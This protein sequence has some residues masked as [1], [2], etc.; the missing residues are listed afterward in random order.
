MDGPLKLLIVESV[1]LDFHRIDR[2]MRQAA[3]PWRRYRAASGDDLEALV[4]DD[5]WAV[6][7]VSSLG[8]G[9]L[10]WRACMARI[11]R[12]H[13]DLPV[14]LVSGRVGAEEAVAA[15]K[16]GA[17]DFVLRDRLGDLGPAIERAVGAATDVQAARLAAAALH[18]SDT[19]L[20]LALIASRMGV[21]EWDIAGDT[22]TV[23]LECKEIMALG[24]GDEPV[25][26]YMLQNLHPDDQEVVRAAKEQ[27][28]A[29]GGAHEIEYRIVCPGS[30]VKWI[31]DHS[32]VILDDDGKP[33]RMLGTIDDVTG[34]KRVEEALR[35]SEM[36]LQEAQRI[37]RMGSFDYDIGNDRWVASAALREILGTEADDDGAAGWGRLIHPAHRERMLAALRETIASGRRFDEEYMIVRP[38]DGAVRWLHGVGE[39]RADAAGAARHIVGMN[40]DITEVRIARERIAGESQKNELLLRMASDGI[41][42]LDADGFVLEASDAFCAMLGYSRQETLGMHVSQWDAQWSA[43]QLVG[44]ILPG[45]LAKKSIFETRHRRRDGEIRDVEI[46]SIGAELEG[47]RVLFAAARDITERRRA[48]QAREA[49]LVEAELWSRLHSEFVANT[50]HE[51]RTPL[52]AI[53]GFA[54]LGL[55]MADGQKIHDTF[56]RILASGQQLLE[57]VGRVLEFSAIDAGSIT[58]AD[59]SFDLWSLIDR[60]SRQAELRARAKGLEFEMRKA[61]D[62]PRFF[63][64]D[65]ERLVRVLAQLLGNAV[66]FTDRGTVTFSASRNGDDVVFRVADSG[67][68]MTR[69]QLDRGFQPFVRNGGS[70]TPRHGGAGLG[71]PVTVR[72]V[73]LMGGSLRVDS[74]ANCGSCFEVRLPLVPERQSGRGQREA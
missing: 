64:G 21:W 34:R 67:V 61:P 11:R 17:A 65:A 69:E 38:A 49:A 29:H 62:L 63:R 55:R 46:S 19:R 53:I 33:R 68:G 39:V 18:E 30:G 56:E 28:L 16:A 60:A 12:R 23:S 48:E 70:S 26:G 7:V 50:G 13:P 9:A 37:G 66:K 58:L 41:H 36:R 73:E 10:D 42:V 47:R 32:A 22:M 44:D 31:H 54:H 52:N 2:Q 6:A 15:L 1:D 51:L 40:R 14:I 45:L 25:D 8:L 27:L 59:A 43:E 35:A 5:G 4:D 24:D 57:L 20:K 72:L 3:G 74:E 71:L